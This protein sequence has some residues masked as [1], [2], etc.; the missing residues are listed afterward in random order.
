MKPTMGLF[1]LTLGA[2]GFESDPGISK[3]GLS[4]RDNIGDMKMPPL[5]RFSPTGSDKRGIFSSA[6]ESVFCMFR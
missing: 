1:F 6:P 4:G 5:K 3:H 2:G